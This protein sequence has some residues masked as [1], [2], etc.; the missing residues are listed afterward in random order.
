MAG[1]LLI[2]RLLA[3]AVIASY[4]VAKLRTVWVTVD[5][6]WRPSWLSR[7]RAGMAVRV[8][9]CWEIVLGLC[10]AVGFPA[11]LPLAAAAGLTGAG[12]TVV[13]LRNIRNSG[14]CGCS[15]A[16]EPIK[17]RE[18]V[19]RNVLL[20][21][22]CVGGALVGPRATTLDADATWAV[23]ALGLV[24]LGLVIAMC[25]ARLSVRAQRGARTHRARAMDPGAL[26]T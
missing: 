1:V 16:T 6:S 2:A 20:F 18:L 11:A 21:G 12:L 4:G 9:S 8:L 23:P 26:T 25:A 22:T 10:V 19:S 13:G 14:T 15:S 3:A 7:R 5:S 24:P 17:A